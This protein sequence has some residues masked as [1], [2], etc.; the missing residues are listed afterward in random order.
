M[1]PQLVRPFR[2]LPVRLAVEF[3]GIAFVV[4]Q[5]CIGEC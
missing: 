1:T 5:I 4:V 3:S 2:I